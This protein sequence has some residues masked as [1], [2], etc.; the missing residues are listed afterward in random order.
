M[1]EILNNNNN[2]IIG[3]IT[4]VYNIKDIDIQTN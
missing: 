2:N 4:N 1:K 3:N